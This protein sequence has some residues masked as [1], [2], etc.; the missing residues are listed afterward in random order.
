VACSR[1]G[2]DTGGGGGAGGKGVAVIEWISRTPPSPF[3]SVI[4]FV[5]RR[6]VVV[7]VDLRSGMLPMPSIVAPVPRAVIHEHQM[8]C[9]KEKALE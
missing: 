3:P 5:W 4:I 8:G 2:G 6:A 7:P 1:E 9:Q